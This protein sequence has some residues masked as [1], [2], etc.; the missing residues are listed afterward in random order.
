MITTVGEYDGASTIRVSATQLGSRYSA[1][2]AR[3][4]VSQWC[5]FFSA[6]PTPLARL[7]FTSRTP[8]RLFE[9]LR[10]QTQ[11]TGLAIK[12]GDYDDLSVV[13]GMPDLKELTLGGAS[14]VRSLTPL[15]TLTKLGRLTVE[16]LRFVHDLS[17]LGSITSLRDLEVGGDWKSP[18]V[19]HVDSIGF[20]RQLPDLRRLILHTMVVD[21]LDYSP[22]L[23]LAALDEVRVAR[24]RGMQPSHD[25]LAAAIPA[26]EALPR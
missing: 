6:G 1:S 8:K 15:G 25:E 5:E 9:S 22:L 3:K 7:A 16:G 12:W 26:F 23:D 24:A 20:L 14:N 13:A 17:P 18:R 4:I 21:D 19:V 10:G 11:L 2:D